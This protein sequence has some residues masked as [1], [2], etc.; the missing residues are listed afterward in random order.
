MSIPKVIRTLNTIQTINDQ[1]GKLTAR[2]VFF[3]IRTESDINDHVSTPFILY[4]VDANNEN[5]NIRLGS[6][7]LI[8]SAQEKA[9][10][11]INEHRSSTIVLEWPD[12]TLR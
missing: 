9:S 4:C 10:C 5:N 3:E 1:I 2:A 12:Y 11:F 6:F 8:G 7:S